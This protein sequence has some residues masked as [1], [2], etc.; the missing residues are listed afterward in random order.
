MKYR[1]TIKEIKNTLGKLNIDYFPEK[2][3]EDFEKEL[4]E[5]IKEGYLSAIEMIDVLEKIKTYREDLNKILSVRKKPKKKGIY[6][7]FCK[8]CGKEIVP[9][10]KLCKN[11]RKKELQKAKERKEALYKAAQENG[12]NIFIK[13]KPS[14]DVMDHPNSFQGGSPGLGKK[15]GSR[16]R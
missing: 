10:A 3:I 15:P 14:K 11:C 8:I 12:I 1:V 5:K 16:S 7:N 6:K 13:I 9:Y 2:K 4:K